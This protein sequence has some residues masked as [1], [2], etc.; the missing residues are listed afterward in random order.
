M[1]HSLAHHLS[2]P[3]GVPVPVAVRV[4]APALVGAVPAIARIGIVLGVLLLLLLLLVLVLLVRQA[5]L[6]LLRIHGVGARRGG[7]AD[8]LALLTLAGLSLLRLGR[9]RLVV[10]SAG[11][12]RLTAR[13]A[14]RTEEPAVLLALLALLTLLSLLLLL[15]LVSAKS[16]RTLTVPA[17]L[18]VLVA[19][20]IVLLVLRV[21]VLLAVSSET[22]KVVV[23]RRGVRGGAAIR[24]V[25]RLRSR[26]SGSGLLGSGRTGTGT[27]HGR[28]RGRCGRLAVHLTLPDGVVL[29]EGRVGRLVVCMSVIRREIKVDGTYT[30]STGC[31]ARSGSNPCSSSSHRPGEAPG[32]A[33][34]AEWGC[35]TRERGCSWALRRAGGGIHSQSS[36]LSVSSAFHY[37]TRALHLL[38]IKHT[39]I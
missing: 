35:A 25:V 4:L 38:L 19:M 2:L 27:G 15:L 13:S 11:S 12:G 22:A 7:T 30:G 24:R 10:V 36:M 32:A 14:G 21:L 34:K 3:S 23:P 37:E 28:R 26:R 18:A 1:I 20:R 31:M 8:L 6:T 9:D 16:R 33:A 17:V 39:P 5:L 29:L